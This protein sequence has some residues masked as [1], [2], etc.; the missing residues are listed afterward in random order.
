VGT[1][2]VLTPLIIVT[3]PV[4]A[5]PSGVV[6]LAYWTMSTPVTGL[7]SGPNTTVMTVST[8]LQ[9]ASMAVSP[10]SIVVGTATI[11]VVASTPPNTRPVATIAAAP[12]PT[13]EPVDMTVVLLRWCVPGAGGGGRGRS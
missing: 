13:R 1:V 7:A 9:L 6:P 12:T 8:S 10:G 5:S 4:S 2:N 11:A 3:V